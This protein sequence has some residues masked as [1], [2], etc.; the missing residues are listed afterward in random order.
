MQLEIAPQILLYLDELESRGV[1]PRP[2]PLAGDAGQNDPETP[3]PPA[4]APMEPTRARLYSCVAG[5]LASNSV[6]VA[7][8]VKMA[9][10]EKL[11]SDFGLAFDERPSIEALRLNQRG[12]RFEN[13]DAH[14]IGHDPNPYGA[15]HDNR[16]EGLLANTR[17]E[18]VELQ[19]LVAELRY[20]RRFYRNGTT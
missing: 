14:G 5:V 1:I 18:G 13:L 6:R 19:S 3:D 12:D 17:A 20:L 8:N 7:T 9:M 10:I 15:L 16:L 4:T 11:I 2:F